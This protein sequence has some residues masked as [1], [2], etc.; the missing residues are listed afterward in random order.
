MAKNPFTSQLE[1]N[2]SSMG[3]HKVSSKSPD[4]GGG[5]TRIIYPGKVISTDESNGM[6][7]IVARI[8][9]LGDDGLENP[10]KDKNLT[11][12]DLVTCIPLLPSHFNVMPIPGEM[13]ILFL[14]N[15]GEGSTNAMRYYIGPIRSTFYN[16]DYE[17][18]VGANKIRNPKLTNISIPIGSLDLVPGNNDVAIQGKKASDIILSSSR[19]RINVAKFQSD[20]LNPNKETFGQ[21]ELIQNQDIKAYIN[22]NRITGTP[23]PN[24][25][26]PAEQFTQ[27][28][29]RGNNINL[30]AAKGSNK[31]IDQNGSENIFTIQDT[32]ASSTKVKYDL[33]VINNPYIFKLGQESESLHPLVFGDNLVQLLSKII[34][35]LETHIHT[36]QNPAIPDSAGLQA[37]L[38]QYTIDSNGNINKL[39]ELISQLVRTN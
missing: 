3:Q 38:L 12:S 26:P 13:V 34:I 33:E 22:Q 24:P 11:D 36:P 10:G 32:K 1:S 20:T 31:T 29:I 9:Q 18:Y 19:V 35:R 39:A 7:R 4:A 8:I 17:D 15:F 14:E 25:T 27:I 16:F 23:I 21:I 6:R 37:D 2:L 30:I 5:S 28:N